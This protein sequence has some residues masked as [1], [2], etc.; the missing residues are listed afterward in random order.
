[1]MLVILHKQTNEQKMIMEM[2][3]EKREEIQKMLRINIYITHIYL[4]VGKTNMDEKMSEIISTLLTRASGYTYLQ[5][6]HS[7]CFAV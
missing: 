5:W 2:D 7:V 6:Y 3:V 4:Y 1:M